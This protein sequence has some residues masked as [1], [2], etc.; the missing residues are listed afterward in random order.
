[1][2][3]RSRK[4]QEFL[5]QHPL[6]CFCGGTL[7]SATIDQVPSRQL[8]NNRAWPEGYEFP[9]CKV[10]N[11]ATR[12][13]EQVVAMLAR[14]YPDPQTE[15]G[16]EEMRRI[17]EAVA[18]NYPAVLQEMKPS[19]RQVRN[20]LKSRGIEKESGKATADY[21]FLAVDG[22][23]VTHC[24]T[25]VAIKLFCA[26]HYK[27]TAVIVPSDGGL[28]FQWRSNLQVFD[29]AIPEDFVTA[30]GQQPTLQR[31]NTSLGDQFFYRFATYSEIKASLFLVWFRQSFAMFECVQEDAS[32]FPQIEKMTIFPPRT[33]SR[34]EGTPQRAM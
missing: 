16:Q 18:F 19:A 26:L 5:R 32:K 14:A 1:M 21:P 11:E 4:R 8:F 20:V 30:L 24:V 34:P 23:L 2:G 25:Q 9:A 28:A 33:P 6:C 3:E 7:P 10:C 12:H 31:C 13:E 27:H 17:V 29:G 15:E 22:P